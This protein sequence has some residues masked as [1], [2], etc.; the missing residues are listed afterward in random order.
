VELHLR[1]NPR[2]RLWYSFRWNHASARSSI[3]ITRMRQGGGAGEL[4]ILDVSNSR[5]WL[6]IDRY[7]LFGSLGETGRSILS[8]SPEC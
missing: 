3:V 5:L 8:V 4:T 6:L 7:G 2:G 1:M